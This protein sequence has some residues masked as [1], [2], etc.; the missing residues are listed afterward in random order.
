LLTRVGFLILLPLCMYAEEFMSHFE[1][2]QMLYN[3][4]RGVSCAKC[5]GEKGEGKVIAV[6]KQEDGKKVALSSPD[7]RELSFAEMV[8]SLN[9]K[10]KIMPKYYLTNDEIKI[11]YDFIQE[12]KKR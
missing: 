10:H 5:H 11:I 12:S 4:P 1:Y 3:N 9:A 7:I 8:K 2:G 6:Y